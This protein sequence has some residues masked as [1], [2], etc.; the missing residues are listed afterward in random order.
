[1]Q[2]YSITKTQ[3]NG[4]PTID[5]QGEGGGPLAAFIRVFSLLFMFIHI[6]TVWLATRIRGVGAWVATQINDVPTIQ[7]L[8]WLVS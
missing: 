4:A 6:I 2:Q 1:M 7:W 5:G 8:G 3:N